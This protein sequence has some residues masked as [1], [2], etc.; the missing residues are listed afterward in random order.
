MRYCAVSEV[1]SPQAQGPAAD[2]RRALVLRYSPESLRLSLLGCAGFAI[3][4]VA[5]LVWLVLTQQQSS[6]FGFWLVVAVM[7]ISFGLVGFAN[8][9]FPAVGHWVA[10]VVDVTGIAL[11]PGPVLGRRTKWG[12]APNLVIFWEDVA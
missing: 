2:P 9:L 5:G 4:G 3:P 6:S 8:Y 7:F 1:P 11:K 12:K 10:V